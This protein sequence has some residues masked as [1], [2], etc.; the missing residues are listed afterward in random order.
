MN[1]EKP[2]ALELL[3]GSHVSTGGGL[4]RALERAEQIQCLSMQVFVKG[5]T[6]WQWPAIKPAEASEFRKRFSESPVKACIA[7]SIYLVNLS[8]TNAEL[9]RKSVTDMVDEVDRCEMYGIPGIVMHPGAHCGAGVEAGIEKIAAGLNLIIEQTPN[10]A[11]RILLES[12]AGQ[13]TGIGSEFVHLAEIIKRV[14][15]KERVGVCVDTCHLFAAGHELRTRE[16]YD[17]V[18]K[19]FE[20]E[21]GFDQLFAVHLNDSKKG[22]GSRVDRHEHIGQG[23]LGLDAFRMLLNDERFRG[24]PMVL[25]TEKDP[26]MEHDKR[27]LRVLRGLIGK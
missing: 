23:E 25:E 1:R 24:I 5:N 3:L 6:R 12:T 20:R 11:C 14:E 19:A 2:L 9:A 4:V 21:I 10:A 17:S 8:A 13:G 18:W 22:L 26:D 27:N 7:H 16:G 15:R